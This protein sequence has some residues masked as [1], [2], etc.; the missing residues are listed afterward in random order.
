MRLKDSFFPFFWI[1]CDCFYLKIHLVPTEIDCYRIYLA[2]LKFKTFEHVF[3][4]NTM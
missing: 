3:S 1:I 4:Q 2:I